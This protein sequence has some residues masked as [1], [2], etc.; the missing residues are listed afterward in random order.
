MMP[1][2]TG[3]IPYHLTVIIADL[4]DMIRAAD[5][6]HK[7]GTLAYLLECAPIEAKRLAEIHREENRPDDG[8]EQWRPV[9]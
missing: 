3:P 9:P 8:S 5:A 1:E 6:G 7:L 2:N 4:E